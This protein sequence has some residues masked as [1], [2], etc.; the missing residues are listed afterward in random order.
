MQYQEMRLKYQK[1]RLKCNTRNLTSIR[2]PNVIH[3]FGEFVF[4]RIFGPKKS[5]IRVSFFPLILSFPRIL[6][7]FPSDFVFS[8]GFVFFPW[9]SWGSNYFFFFFKIRGKAIHIFQFNLPITEVRQTDITFHKCEKI[10]KRLSRVITPTRVLAMGPHMGGE[11]SLVKS[12]GTN[13]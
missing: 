7:F 2:S 11:F 5:I 1:M 10:K 9:I 8:S 13:L 6:S 12:H 4:P 3:M